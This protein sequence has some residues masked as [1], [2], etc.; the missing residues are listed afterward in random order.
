VVDR[1]ILEKRLLKLERTIH[2]LRGLSQV[3]WERFMEGEGI[4]DRAERN[5]QTA[6]Q[7]CID[8]GSHIIADSGHRPP[9]SYAD[10]FN[11]LREEGLL[12]ESLASRLETPSFTPGYQTRHLFV[13]NPRQTVP[14]RTRGAKRNRSHH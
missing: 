9:S 13:D 14:A 1:V 5:L 10:V 3:S 2:K 4:R 12:E 8:M 11:V 7:V 6:I